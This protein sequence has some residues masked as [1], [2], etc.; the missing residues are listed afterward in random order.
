MDFAQGD[1]GL[2]CRAAQRCECGIGV[3]YQSGNV[4]PTRTELCIPKRVHAGSQI[5]HA[6]G[7]TP[8]V[9]QRG[10][11]AFLVLGAHQLVELG[12]CLFGL[13]EDR[14][15]LLEQLVQPARLEWYARRV[16][17]VEHQAFFGF[18]VVI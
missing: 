18:T 5:T 11:D 4:D 10:E 12:R 14:F 7:G 16:V 3:L 1:G 9:V 13:V 17:V 15:A 2:V 6:A 8:D